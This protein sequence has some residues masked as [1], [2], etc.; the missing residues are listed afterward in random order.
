MKKIMLTIAIVAA[1]IFANAASVEWSF[2]ATEKASANPL[3]LSTYQAF[4]FTETAWNS[5][6]STID[7][8]KIDFKN[9]A[10]YSGEG[11]DITKSVMGGGNA[12][13]F[14]TGTQTTEGASGSYYLVLSD[15][16]TGVIDL[17]AKDMTAFTNPTEQHISGSWS[18]SATGTPI[19]SVT[20][21]AVPEPTSGL[22]LI[23]G[24]AGLALRRRC[25]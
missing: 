3:D 9:F 19:T 14:T 18:I 22:L 6:L 17:G 20:Y 21:A 5:V 11:V 13:K 4:L 7:E 15:G 25:A 12:Y 23:L 10:G 1:A 2:T 16:K 8:G 24:M